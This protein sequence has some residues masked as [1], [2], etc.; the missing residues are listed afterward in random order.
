MLKLIKN[1]L[2]FVEQ[3]INLSLSRIS[4]ECMK[5]AKNKRGHTLLE[6]RLLALFHP[7][8]KLFPPMIA[9]HI[10]PSVV[11]CTELFE[12]AGILGAAKLHSFLSRIR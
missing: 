5:V 1:L 11:L 12:Q 7:S 8:R 3:R 4:F 2:N 10:S 6:K 9:R